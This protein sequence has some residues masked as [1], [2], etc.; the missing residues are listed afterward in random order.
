M[1]RLSVLRFDNNQLTRIPFAI[2]RLK[3]LRVLHLSNNKVESLPHTLTYNNLT[4]ID[5]TENPFS[6]QLPLP[7][8][9]LPAIKRIVPA[10]WEIAGRVV[11]KDKIHY[12]PQTLPRFLMDLLEETP[13]CPCGLICF[14]GEIYRNCKT[15]QLRSEYI[16]RDKSLTSVLLADSVFCKTACFYKYADRYNRQWPPHR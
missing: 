10:L 12:S 1:K 5:I 2:R 3:S 15:L 6:T 14:T 8:P 11:F 9:T 16:V 7:A 4:T 13:L